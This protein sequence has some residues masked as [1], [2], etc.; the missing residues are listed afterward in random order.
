MKKK[1]LKTH[2]KNI[3]EMMCLSGVIFEFFCSKFF[4]LLSDGLKNLKRGCSP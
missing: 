3:Y 4:S 2:K 1:E